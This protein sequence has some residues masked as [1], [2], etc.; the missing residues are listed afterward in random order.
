MLYDALQRL[1]DLQPNGFS[2]DL[3][4]DLEAHPGKGRGGRVGREEGG[5]REER[6]EGEDCRAS[7][8]FWEAGQ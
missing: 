5:G 4:T 6:G 2:Y 8:S 3:G 1:F 7:G